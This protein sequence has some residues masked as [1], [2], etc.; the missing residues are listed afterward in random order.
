MEL[1][2]VLKKG[3]LAVALAAG[4]AFGTPVT[5]YVNN[6]TGNDLYDGLAAEWDGVHGPKFKIQSAIE[7]ASVGDVVLV[8]PGVYGDEQG[9]VAKSTAG[10]T[11]RVYI[12][13][14]ITLASSGTRENTAIVG[15]R[16]DTEDGTGDGGITG[17]MVASSVATGA[18]NP[19]E[20]KGFTVRDCYSDAADN[21]YGCVIGWRASKTTPTFEA[22][23]GPWVVDCAISNCA[24]KGHGALGR[25]NAA[26][27]LVKDV[28]NT[29]NVN[30]VLGYYCN[31]VF[32]VLA[33][34]FGQVGLYGPASQYAIN[35]TVTDEPNNPCSTS[36]AM[37][38]LN[39]TITHT[40]STGFYCTSISNCV[41]AGSKAS[42]SGDST[43]P[44]S[45]KGSSY[46]YGQ[47]AAVMFNDYRPVV[48]TPGI[49]STSK[50]V[51]NG[52]PMWLELVPEQYRGL[53]FNGNTFS[54]DENGMIC[55]GAV[56]TPMTPVSGFYLDNTDDV[57]RTLV[58]GIRGA[59]NAAGA[60]YAT[61]VY[62]DAASWPRCFEITAQV[63]EGSNLVG[64]AL[65]NDLGMRFPTK[66]GK[67]L[68]VPP[69]GT[70]TT[71]AAKLASRT[72]YVDE[73]TG[74]DDEYDGTS[75]TV[76]GSS[77]PYATIQKAI[78]QFS[79]R[80]PGVI[81]VAPGMYR[82]GAREWGAG[83][84]PLIRV[85]TSSH[86]RLRI[87]ST[88]S[89][90]DTFIIG[91]ADTT[92]EERDALGNGPDAV[93]CVRFHSSCEC[94]LQGFTLTGGHTDSSSHTNLS[95]WCSGG[96]FISETAKCWLLDC[97]I[98]NNCAAV[99]GV[100]MYGGSAARCVFADNRCHASD[101]TMFF[102]SAKISG[103]TLFADANTATNIAIGNGIT[104]VNC[105][106]YGQVSANIFPTGQ[107]GRLYN[108]LIINNK[109]M[110]SHNSSSFSAGNVLDRTTYND[111]GVNSEGVSYVKGD[112][113]CI[114]ESGFDLRLTSGSA[115]IGAGSA[116]TTLADDTYQTAGVAYTNYYALLSHDFDGNRPYFVD[117]NP[118]AGAYQRPVK[119]LVLAPV[120]ARSGFSVS[121]PVT[122]MVDFGE[123]FTV[124]TTDGTRKVL[125]LEVNGE[126]VAGTS[127]TVNAPQMGGREMTTVSV[128]VNTNWY[129]DAVNGLDTNPGWTED[130]PVKTLARAMRDVDAGDV[131]VALPGT[132]S[133]GSMI[134]D[135]VVVPEAVTPS[136]RAR[137]LVPPKVTL[138]SRDG[139]E[140]TVIKGEWADTAD[141]IGEGAMRCVFM[142]SG[143]RLSGFT[144]TGGAT[145]TS[146]S[147][148]ANDNDCGG[149]VFCADAMN[150]AKP[151]TWVTDCIISNNIAYKGGGVAHG[152]GYLRCRFFENAAQN[153]GAAIFQVS[154][155]CNSIIDRNRG[156]YGAYQPYVTRSCTFGTGSVSWDGKSSRPAL[157]TDPS[158]ATWPVYNSLFLGG[159]R[160][161]VR[162]ATHCMVPSESFLR[163][164]RATSNWVD[165]VVATVNV[166][167]KFAPDYESAA[168][169]AA[170]MG[171]VNAVELEGDVYGNQRR[172]NGGMD[173]GAVEK[174]WRPRYAE[175]LGR[176]VS[177]TDA[178]WDVIETGT[179]GVLIPD[180]GSLAADWNLG[181]RHSARSVA[182]TVGEG[183]TLSIVR[184]G[185]EPLVYGPGSW[186]W[187]SQDALASDTFLFSASGGDVELHRFD[188]FDSFRFI[189]R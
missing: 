13:K 83:Y 52:D 154:W 25:V 148:T 89:A 151:A 68:F 94:C 27:T 157:L 29:A 16:A 106:S 31:F 153:Y 2:S 32:C 144:L 172:F 24:Y 84:K 189:I 170:D 161:Y 181:G 26:R 149:G 188:I 111:R 166:D 34:G 81:Y 187:K 127:F 123:S 104:A 77:G 70:Y 50:L 33:R 186:E 7:A 109:K 46:N 74:D 128:V 118:T 9:S 137:V 102:N 101:G 171:I 177:V 133:E 110:N 73:K 138:V 61:R 78:D 63:P 53:D 75:P 42:G 167:D 62:L 150:V 184:N 15:K 5:N 17:I 45:F 65:S 11:C 60:T 69:K 12:N 54:P 14:S 86:H 67:I 64:F 155:L 129:A 76:D 131:V 56:Q 159:T 183:A 142:G 82:T 125:R 140:A 49:C 66:D 6:V 48:A 51:G 20:I 107:H 134:Q 121:V 38:F 93:R 120:N 145:K 108:N 156:P 1:K 126:S 115:A 28:A 10:H 85:R 124:S 179:R 79:D 182:F 90:E 136:L 158:V 30:G 19:V 168:A 35:T 135:E 185:A 72:Y 105:S 98:S 57:P 163:T 47:L 141:R 162:H 169:N 41:M 87:V 80:T 97:I 3:A 22:G 164:D 152:G 165:L 40:S 117:G 36:C 91:E 132:Y 59:G 175:D 92:S 130:V 174:D 112:A 44:K 88:G 103:C 113:Y 180:G 37:Y 58:E 43:D 4:T 147:A 116:W 160:C 119:Y 55:V 178:T 122:N 8:A 99:N 71:V 139:A 100:A 18:D 95:S 143:A 173:I 114:D 39:S 23:N 96:A 146:S 176:R 21:S